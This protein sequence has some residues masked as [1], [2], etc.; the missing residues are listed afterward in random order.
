MVLVEFIVFSVIKM[1]VIFIIFVNIESSYEV[2]VSDDN[3]HRIYI[4]VLRRLAQNREAARKS[5][6]RKKVLRQGCA[7]CIVS[8]EK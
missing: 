6:L 8:K 2:I 5:R 3:K 7:Y 4:Q 1:F